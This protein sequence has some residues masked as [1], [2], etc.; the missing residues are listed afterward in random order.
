MFTLSKKSKDYRGQP[1]HVARLIPSRGS[2]LDFEF[3]HNDLVYVRIDKKKKI[4][5]T[6][7]LQ[8]I[9]IE[10]N[11]I[12]STFYNFDTVEVKSGN[13]YR[14]LDSNII[15]QRLEAGAL[16]KEFEG[17][18]AVGQR[19][20]KAHIDKLQ[21]EGIDR[22]IVRKNSLMSRIVAQDI[23][24]PKTGEVIASLGTE[25]TEELIEVI[26]SVGTISF[27]IIQSSGYVIQPTLALTFAQDQTSTREEALKEVYTKLKPGDIPSV[28]IMEEYR[29]A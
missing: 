8:A 11:K 26:A 20:T 12:L 21:K 22:L 4:L 27:K 6:T 3:D 15:G 2:W 7:F 13:F 5:A 29:Q 25:L 10:K 1:Y 24:A 28:K 18:V 16:P 9:G 17:K 23:I 19:L 14:K